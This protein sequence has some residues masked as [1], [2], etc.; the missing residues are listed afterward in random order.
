MIGHTGGDYGVST[1]MF[2]RPNKD[3]GVVSLTNAY[4]SG[5]QWASFTDIETRMFAEFS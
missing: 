3:V 2:Y 4:I 5:T 1:R